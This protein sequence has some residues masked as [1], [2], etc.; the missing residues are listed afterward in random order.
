MPSNSKPYS[1]REIKEKWDDITN[2]LSRIEVQTTTTN[3]RVNALEKWKYMG[4]GATTILSAVV[5]PILFWAISVL[6]NIDSRIQQS[7]DRALSS[8]EINK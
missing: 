7:V 2:A 8:Y 5:I 4:M 6:V 3:G 1:N